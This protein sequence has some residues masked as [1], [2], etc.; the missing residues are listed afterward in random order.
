MQEEERDNETKKYRKSG[1]EQMLVTF[2]CNLLL[3]R[4]TPILIA[5]I[6]YKAVTL[7]Q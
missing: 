6:T 2:F 5:E 4:S 1:N 3:Q 7:H